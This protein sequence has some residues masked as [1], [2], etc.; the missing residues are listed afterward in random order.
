MKELVVLVGALL[1]ARVLPIL[2]PSYANFTPLFAVAIFFPL[3]QSKLLSYSVPLGVMFLTDLFL[4]FSAINLVVY[5]VLALII[6]LSRSI[7][8][9]VYTSI[10]GIGLWHVI[11]NF[12]VWLSNPSMSLLQ[13]YAMAIPFDFKLL[14]ST[15]VYGT[16]LSLLLQ[17]KHAYT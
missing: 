17:R 4:G 12:F 7:N 2:D 11:V 1:L 15:L 16:A 6:S 3:T 5:F 8:N 10:I 14:L 13:T 9:Y